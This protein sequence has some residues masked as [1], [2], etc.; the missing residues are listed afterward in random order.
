MSTAPQLADPQVSRTKFN[1]EVEEFRQLAG[2]YARRGWLLVEAE[3]PRVFVVMAAPQ[4][5]PPPIVTGVLLDYTDYDLRPPSVQLA[6]PFSREPYKAG[7]LPTSLL[8]QVET[9][10]MPIGLALP[11]GVVAPRM[12]QQQPLM[13]SYGPEELPFLCI[14]GVREYHEHPAH[15]GD[16][17]E[18]HRRDGAGR[19]VRILEVIDT[20]GIRPVNGYGVNLVP[21]VSGLTQGEVPA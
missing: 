3:F 13:Q 15:S 7:E 9:D 2:D 6:D 4:L 1:R 18:L 17:W 5:K 21:Q 11:P 19:L 10:A 8:R 14:A 16:R 12:I 20:Y